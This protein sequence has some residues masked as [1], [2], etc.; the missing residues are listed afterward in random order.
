MG[1]H[2]AHD[3]DFAHYAMARVLFDRNRSKEAMSAILE[4]IRLDS[5]QPQYFGLMASIHLHECEWAQALAAAERGLQLDPENVSCTN[6][7]AMALVKLGRKMEAGASIAAALS[8]NP[9][10]SVTHANNGW[11]LLEEGQPEKA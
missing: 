3:F 5:F 10:N 11:R 1:I 2:H 9:D 8:K 7:R 4:A 6:L